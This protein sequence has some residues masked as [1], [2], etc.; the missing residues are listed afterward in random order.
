MSSNDILDNLT[1]HTV[2]LWTSFL[3]SI[4]FVDYIDPPF[5]VHILALSK[6]TEVMYQ[7]YANSMEICYPELFLRNTCEKFS[8]LNLHDKKVYMIRSTRHI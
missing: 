2:A 8:G 6:Y 5:F 3:S 4:W 7:N 1:E